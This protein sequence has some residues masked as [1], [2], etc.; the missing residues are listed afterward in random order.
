MALVINSRK[1]A[2]LSLRDRP[3]TRYLATTL[4]SE[5]VSLKHGAGNCGAA[6]RVNEF[7]NYFC[8][9][10]FKE[11][12]LKKITEIYAYLLTLAY[13]ETGIRLKLRIFS[14]KKASLGK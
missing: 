10:A 13:L 14:L 11:R 8:L 1:V 7:P 12:F 5:H 4:L 9:R 3:W 2:R 6:R